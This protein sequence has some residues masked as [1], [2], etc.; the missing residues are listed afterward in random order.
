MT[1]LGNLRVLGTFDSRGIDKGTG[2]ARKSF[3]GLRDDSKKLEERFKALKTSI[4]NI[5]GGVA[6]GLTGLT[7]MADRFA[8]AEQESQRLA[9][10]LG[11]SRGSLLRYQH[12]ADRLSVS[13]DAINDALLELNRRSAEAV[14]GT[15]SMAESLKVLNIDANRFVQLSL[16]QKFDLIAKTLS[17]VQNVSQRGFLTDEIFGGSSDELTGFIAQLND[18]AKG[19]N[20]VSIAA[21]AKGLTD[22]A[23]TWKEIT[24]ELKQAGRGLLVD[25]SP[26]ALESI[27]GLQV[28]IDNLPGNTS[29]TA[30]ERARE[31][32]GQAG[33]IGGFSLGN[34]RQSAVDFLGEVGAGFFNTQRDSD[35][36][37]QNARLARQLDRQRLARYRQP[38]V[39]SRPVQLQPA[40]LQ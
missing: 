20:A 29:K 24:T 27:R 9:R 33:T 19:L 3:K 1:I 39:N 5:S 28:I 31:A 4:R 22:F 34:A 2:K 17:Q 10:G 40:G 23:T 12:A 25:V 8:N 35:V 36:A 14:T 37:F 13:Q 6:G 30:K 26:I 11:I 7:Y 18:T 16:E 15:G 38:Q 21:E 32:A